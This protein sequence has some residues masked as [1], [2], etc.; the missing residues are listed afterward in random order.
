M[1]ER[2]RLESVGYNPLAVERDGS[3]TIDPLTATRIGEGGYATTYRVPAQPGLPVGGVLKV[4][5][6]FPEPCRAGERLRRKVKWNALYDEYNMLCALDGL[7]GHVPQAYAYG[8]FVVDDG[9]GGLTYSPAFLMEE[10][11]SPAEPLKDVVRERTDAFDAGQV[12]VFGLRALDALDLLAERGEAAD[13]VAHADLSPA[14]VFVRRSPDGKAFEWVYLIDFGQAKYAARG[15]TPSFMRGVHP[16]MGTVEYCAPELIPQLTLRERDSDACREH[17]E[18]YGTRSDATVDLWSLGALMYLLALRKEPRYSV[19][20]AERGGA[21]GFWRGDTLLDDQEAFRVLIEEKRRGLSL[22]GYMN[23]EGEL[24]LSQAIE[25]CTAWDPRERDR[26]HIRRLLKRVAE[27]AGDDARF[28]RMTYVPAVTPA[29]EDDAEQGARVEPGTVFAGVY[30][31]IAP[32]GVPFSDTEADLLVFGDNEQAVDICEYRYRGVTYTAEHVGPRYDMSRAGW[33]VK[34]WQCDSPWQSIKVVDFLTEVR[35]ATT[36]AWF[37]GCARL[38]ELLHIERLNTSAVT[39]MQFMFHDCSS[40]EYVDVFGFDTSQVERMN[41][42]FHGC[43]ALQGLNVGGFD[44]SKVVTMASMFDG[45][46]SLVVLDVGRFKTDKVQSFS[47]MFNECSSV[48]R[49]DVSHFKTGAATNLGSMFRRCRS[50]ETVDVSRFDTSSATSLNGMFMGCE[51]LRDVDVSGFRTGSVTNF[52]SLFSGCK[53]LAHVDV[54]GFDTSSVTFLNHMF[55][56]CAELASIDVSGFDTSRATTF[57]SMFCGC[58]ALTALDVSGFDTS[59]AT[60]MAW[61]FSKC[62]ALT[63]ID[64]SGFRTGSV[65]DF[66][67]MFDGCAELLALDTSRFDTSAATRLNHMFYGCGKLE[68]LDVSGFRTAR[69]ESFKSM[70]CGCASLTALDVSGFDCSSA[71]DLSFMFKDCAELGSIGG[72][73]R[74]VRDD[75]DAGSMYTG[76]PKLA[77][78]TNVWAAMYKLRRPDGSAYS[79]KEMDLLVFGQGERGCALNWCTMGGERLGAV[80]VGDPIDMSNKGWNVKDGKSESPWQDVETVLFAGEISP[81]T[82]CAWFACCTR[83]KSVVGI[84]RLDTSQVTDMRLAFYRCESLAELDVSGFDTSSATDMAWMFSKCSAL[85]AIDVSGFRTGSVTDFRS[86]FADCSSLKTLDISGFDTSAATRLNH[87]FHRCGKLAAL[88]VSGFRTG[89]VT[90]FQSMFDGCSS[91]KTLDVSGFD[92]S[93]AE[94]F[95][96]MFDECSALV[97]LDVSRFDTSRAVSFNCMFADCHALTLLDVSGFA[98]FRATDMRHMFFND[99]NLRRLDVSRFRTLHVESFKS[100]FNGCSSLRSLDVSRFDTSAATDMGWMF[101]GCSSIAELD[102]SRFDTSAATRLDYMF[103]GCS[104]LAALDVSRFDTSRVTSFKCMFYGC[105][106]LARLDVSGFTTSNATDLSWMLADCTSLVDLRGWPLPVPEGADT[107]NI[108]RGLP[109]LAVARRKR[110]EERK[111]IEEAVR[112]RTRDR[113]GVDRY[114]TD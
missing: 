12:A 53:V 80:R 37:A 9:A 20:F 22:P 45:C 68:A 16:R 98:T 39:D 8:F 57:K 65:T 76:C 81:R 30:K 113:H 47:F 97:S 64:V 34:E 42:M 49:L 91:L 82:M 21:S 108:A 89:S 14:N 106:N 94:H 56:E 87:M 60:D 93:A 104:K 32:D 99:G 46:S 85:T 23:E 100:M 73:L 19:E 111:K 95:E 17:N 69:V 70:F 74:S 13:Q 72:A 31:L 55:Y 41:A 103:Y 90:D 4:F 86:M 43:S 83:L 1:G 71:T 33:G 29:L 50:L 51:S 7:D 66:Q 6:L 11:G 59:S 48:R 15:V 112:M 28:M 102:T 26:L 114:Y 58:I 36:R 109:D 2:I 67:S 107:S 77:A 38:T 10:I 5:K 24:L 3:R 62:S 61:M 96:H 40:L 101:K 79:D 35:P 110:E 84:E 105:T 52:G 18:L 75:A 27:G 88:D 44:T 92:T 54:S 78:P 25:L 63:T